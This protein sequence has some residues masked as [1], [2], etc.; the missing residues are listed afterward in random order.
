MTDGTLLNNVET[1]HAYRGEVY[2]L[3]SGAWA[4]RVTEDGEEFSRGAGFEDEIEAAEACS[5]V[6]PF[7]DFPISLIADPAFVVQADTVDQCH[8]LMMLPEQRLVDAI[9]E[10]TNEYVARAGEHLHADDDGYYSNGIHAFY[11]LVQRLGMSEEFA[12]ILSRV[13]F[14]A[15]PS[16]FLPISFSLLA[17]D[18]D[19]E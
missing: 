11:D 10:L 3:A 4:F 19:A 8:P 7:V 15:G 12:D 18:E 5:D 1:S 6:V 14:A 9:C 16:E 17:N 2:C 13:R